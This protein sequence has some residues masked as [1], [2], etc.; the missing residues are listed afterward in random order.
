MCIPLR[1]SM[2]NQLKATAELKSLLARMLLCCVLRPRM[3]YWKFSANSLRRQAWRKL[4]R[5]IVERIHSSS[6]AGH[7]KSCSTSYKNMQFMIVD[8][9]FHFKSLFLQLLDS[10][11]LRYYCNLCDTNFLHTADLIPASMNS[12]P[13]HRK[14]HI[15]VKLHRSLWEKI[16]QNYEVNISFTYF[17]K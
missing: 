1:P 17:I 16:T 15:C 14:S 6:Q 2:Q 10:S 12:H 7:D 13:P 3:F 4:S 11:S 5:A 8:S 9:L